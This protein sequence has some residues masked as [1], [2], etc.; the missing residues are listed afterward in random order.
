M[1]QKFLCNF[2]CFAKNNYHKYNLTVNDI[3]SN[4]G[5][6]KSY[7]HNIK[8]RNQ[9]KGLQEALSLMPEGSKWEIVIPSDL[10]YSDKGYGKIIGP[11]EVLIFIVELL[12]VL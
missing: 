9:I 1:N 10:A 11:N 6:S 5:C 8:I 2:I 3:C 4:I 12:K 7:L